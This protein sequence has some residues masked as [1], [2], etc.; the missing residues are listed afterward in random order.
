MASTTDSA[1]R[2]DVEPTD[3]PAPGRKAVFRRAIKE[4]QNDDLT[5]W[6][7]AL[8]YYSVLALFPAL[9]V[10]V[11]LMGLFGQYPQTT[12]HLLHILNDIG[13]PAKTT[14]SL[15]GTIDSVITKKGGAGEIGRASC[16][17]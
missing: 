15:R 9:I 16:R 10:L 12:D 2:E 8:T 6:A 5:D 7:A 17:E 13:V 4:F 1:L 14:Q 11:A 3:I